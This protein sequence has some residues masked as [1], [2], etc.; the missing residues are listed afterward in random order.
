MWIE[1]PFFRYGTAVIMLLLIIF[2]LGKIDYFLWPF[3]KL[4]ATVFFPL[5]ISGFL[6]YILRPPVRLLSRYIP[7]TPSILLVFAL[8]FGLGYVFFHFA[9]P[10][11]ANQ[12]KEISAHFPA[13]VA[14][15]T[16]Q[17][18]EMVKN[19]ENAKQSVDNLGS[20]AR[21]MVGKVFHK[22]EKNIGNV[23]SAIA[24]VVT[25]LAV[26]PFIVFYLLKD[27][28]K[29]QPA[30]LKHLPDDRKDEGRKILLDIDKTLSSYIVG[31]FIIA[32]ADGILLYGG[33]LMIGLDSALLLALFATSVAV[34]PF[35]GPILGILPAVM[36][37]LTDSPMLVIKV[38][39]VMFFVQQLEGNLI[40]PRVMGNKL[41]LHPLT[42]IFVLLIAGSVYGF[43]GII[44]AIPLF[45]VLK[46]TF[47]N[48]RKF[49]N[50]N[51][52]KKAI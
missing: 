12:V 13:K 26:V 28:E 30:L 8:L 34:V 24:S 6:Y 31:Q 14:E 48:I 16:D 52:I 23:V 40:T 2:L 15:F 33:Y 44:I 3:Q 47:N 38:L 39:L 9:G 51:K 35:L 25:V 32:V 42:V 20:K 45:S 22:A 50:L 1:K 5:L 49:Y 18:K 7:K 41:N 37:A 43:I 10:S 46:V 19:N 21:S 27:S 17:S 11:I 36:I 29:L 4:V